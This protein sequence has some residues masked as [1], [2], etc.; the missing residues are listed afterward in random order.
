MF[1]SNCGKKIEDG[2]LFCE[3]CGSPQETAAANNTANAGAGGSFNVGNAVGGISPKAKKIIIGAV[4]GVAV[5]AAA[6]FGGK[7]AY[8]KFHKEKINLEDYVV[9]YYGTEVPYDDDYYDEDAAK[10][11]QFDGKGSVVVTFNTKKLE[12]AIKKAA[13]IKGKKSL[14]ELADKKD[15]YEDLYEVYEELV[16]PETFDN[17]KNGDEVTYEFEYDND[18]ISK[19]G[20]K[21]EGDS[22][23]YK[24]D[25][26]A[27]VKEIDPFADV[28]VTFDGTA[29]SAYASYTNNSTEDALE[30]VYFTFDH[31]YDLAIGDQVTLKIDDYDEEYYVTNYGVIFS[32]TENTYTCEGVDSYVSSTSEVGDELLAE[33]KE[34]AGDKIDDYFDDYKDEIKLEGTLAYEGYYLSKYKEDYGNN[35]IYVVYSGTVHNK[36]NDGKKKKDDDYDKDAFKDTKVYFVVRFSDAINYADGE[37]TYYDYYDMIG[38][39]DLSFGWWSTVNGFT[40]VEDMTDYIEDYDG[41]YYEMVGVVGD[42]LTGSVDVA[43]PETEA[44]A[45]TEAATEEASEVATEEAE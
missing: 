12:K 8:N 2:S 10:E 11:K 15:E 27:E 40:S 23:V 32:K 35:H 37:F 9:M 7:A 26:L 36:A 44:P 24:I 31:N 28:E 21:F 34:K 19:Y 25:G 3:F 5:I 39:S 42:N 22:K 18:A 33:L 41:S 4:A 43:E 20:I 13:D 6:V 16:K 38:S 1:C 30:Y 14:E 45:E 17:L 29:P